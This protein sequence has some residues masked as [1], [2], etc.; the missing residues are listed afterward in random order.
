[1]LRRPAPNSPGENAS[2]RRVPPTHRL[3]NSYILFNRAPGQGMNQA[4][5]ERSAESSSRSP[6]TVSQPRRL[7]Y[8]DRISYIFSCFRTPPDTTVAALKVF[9]ATAEETNTPCWC[10]S[11]R[12]IGGRPG[13]TVELVGPGQA[14]IRP[15]QPQERGMDGLVARQRREDRWRNGAGRSACFRRPTWLPPLHGGLP[16]GNP[17]SGSRCHGWQARLPQDR[18]HLLIGSSWARN[19]DRVNAYYYPSGNDLLIVPFED[20]VRRW[21]HR[22]Y[23]ERDPHIGYA[24]LKS[25]GIRGDGVPTES[26]LRDVAQ[27]YLEMLCREA[28]QAGVPRDCLFAHGAGW[29]EGELV[30]D[31]PVNPYACPGWSFYHHAADPR[32]D[33]G[34]QRNLA[35]S[36]APYWAAT[37]WLLQGTRTTDAWRNALTNTLSDPRC[38]YVCIFNWESIRSS[39]TVLQAIAELVEASLPWK[40]PYEH[41]G[42][43]ETGVTFC[44]PLNLNYG[45]SDKGYRHGADPV[46]VLFKDRYYLFSTWDLPGYRV[47]DDLSPGPSSVRRCSRPLMGAT[48]EG[49]L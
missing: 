17:A 23:V 29:K 45:W 19:L 33:S 32:K 41:A 15:G 31:V 40:E 43:A 27:R 1:M 20:P 13:P 46:V 38:R 6:G 10:R 47:S 18:K 48:P 4:I 7:T 28:T 39:E 30:Y 25:S 14:R 2:S 36:D 3:D 49:T 37:E 34:V 44:N 26:E 5:P 35:R 24:D 12:N 16:R 42:A 9:M 21:T 11:I 22:T 8:P